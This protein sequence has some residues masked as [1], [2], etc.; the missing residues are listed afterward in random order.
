MRQWHYATWKINV[1][2]FFGPNV[3]TTQID[4]ALNEAGRA[5]WELVSITDLNW[6]QGGSKFLLYT[7]KRP[8][9]VGPAPAPP[10]LPGA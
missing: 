9:G 10:P 8:V 1:S 7:F 5:G 2:G 4:A 6:N 3:E